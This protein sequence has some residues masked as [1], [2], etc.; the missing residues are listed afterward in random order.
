MTEG[1]RT[2]CRL[3]RISEL[4]YAEGDPLNAK[5]V[6]LHL[7]QQKRCRDGEVLQICL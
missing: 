6:R 5:S 7:V 3:N 4:D 1:L 2:A